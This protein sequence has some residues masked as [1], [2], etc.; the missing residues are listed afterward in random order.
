MRIAIIAALI[1]ASVLMLALAAWF[2]I[3]SL[4]VGVIA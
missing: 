4:P 1:S 3:G 2:I